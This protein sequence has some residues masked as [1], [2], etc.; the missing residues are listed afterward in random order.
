MTPPD[1]L[2]LSLNLAAPAFF[3]ALG[4]AALGAPALAW[5][6]GLLAR[7]RSKVFYAKLGRQVADMGLWLGL[8]S[9]ALAAISCVLTAL[10]L[11]WITPWLTKPGSPFVWVFAL[12]LLGLACLIPLRAGLGRPRVESPAH[13]VLGLPAALVPVAVVFLGLAG[14]RGIGR[15]TL[16]GADLLTLPPLS[17]LLAAPP[18]SLL[19]PLFAASLCLCAGLAGTTALLYL[20][21]RRT[22]DD[23]GRD[24]YVFA[25][26]LSAR[27]AAT[28]LVLHVLS[29]VWLFAAMP[30]E[31]RALALAGPTLW[32]FVIAAGLF[33][34]AAAALS[35]VAGN[36]NPLRLK[37]LIV[38][39]A[40][41]SWAGL[42]LLMAAN[43]RLFL[44]L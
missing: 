38:G 33:A 25:L 7:S 27:S 36:T 23:F 15:L 32:A 37:G 35:L 43:L 39:A 44:S 18:A 5:S 1:L 19:W 24:Y 26:R 2:L 13:L 4:L 17:E 28:P 20:L 34:A 16:A 8:F 40:V 30:L 21:A 10:R 12:A 14:M 29:L 3:K 41:A 22:R 42:T 6:C 31:L 11:A 9:L